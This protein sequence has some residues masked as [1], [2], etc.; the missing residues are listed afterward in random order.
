MEDNWIV[1][2]HK[3]LLNITLPG[4]HNS[5]N[6]GDLS[7]NPKCASQYDQYYSMFKAS[8]TVRTANLTKEEYDAAFIPWN[9]NHHNDILQ[10]LQGGIRYFHLKVCWLGMPDQL[11][12]HSNSSMDLTEVYH[13]HRG[14]TS[15]TVDSILSTVESFLAAHPKEVVALTFNN[16]D[17]MDG[18]GDRG[19]FAQA[20]LDHIRRAGH[21]PIKAGTLAPAK[22]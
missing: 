8:W 16:L 10:Q 22:V 3:S 4:S 2:Q 14:F 18:V 7:G 20:I 5:G 13:H 15:I 11:W 9:I 19:A 17:Q 21:G 6:T 12:Q 1:L